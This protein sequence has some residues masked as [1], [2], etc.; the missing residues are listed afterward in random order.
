MHFEIEY[1]RETDGRWIAEVS[2]LPGVLVYGSSKE[3]AESRVLVLLCQV[4]KAKSGKSHTARRCRGCDTWFAGPLKKQYCAE[5]CQKHSFRTS[6]AQRKRN[7]E[8]QREYYAKNLASPRLGKRITLPVQTPSPS[9]SQ[10]T[11]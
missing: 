7:A 9:E 2:A 6:P 10:T 11:A 3:N 5:S 4:L 1:D 8:Y